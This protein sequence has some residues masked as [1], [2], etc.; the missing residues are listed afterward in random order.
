MSTSETYLSNPLLKKSNISIEFTTEQVEEYI[1]CGEDAEYFIEK[2]IKI[3]SIDKGLIS[4]VPYDYQRKMIQTFVDNRFV[5]AKCPRQSGKSTTVTSYLLWRILFFD[6]QNVAI[7]ANKGRLA[8]DLLEKIKLAYENLPKWIQQGVTTWNKGNIELENGSKVLAAATSSSAIRGGSYNTILLDEFA[9]IPRN[10]AEEFFTS[11]YPTISSGTTSQIIIVSTPHGM[12]HYYKMWVDA[13]EK[14]SLYIP[15]E[16]GWWETPGRDEAWKKQIIANTSEEQFRQEFE[17][18]FLGSANTLINPVKLKELTFK[19]P[20]TD[21]WGL[22]IYEEPKQNHL[23]IIP[24]DTAFGIGNDYSAFVVID[25]T[26]IPY[27]IVA[28][29]RSNKI[30]PMLYPEIICRYATWYN[31]AYILPE[32][33]DVGATV[34]QALHN[35]LEYENIIM[36]HN[37]VGLGQSISTGFGTQQT[38]FGI[39]MTKQVKRLGCSVLK[40]LVEENKI[41]IEDFDIINEFS[42]FISRS[43]SY[44]AED[45]YHDDLVM[46]LVIFC[47]FVRQ[48]FFKELSDTD[49][50]GRLAKEKYAAMLDDLLPPGFIDDGREENIT[51]MDGFIFY[52]D[53]PKL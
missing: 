37:K 27:R 48:P 1:R 24:V 40:D 23:Y 14:R 29:Y 18:V 44:E 45:G 17:C 19:T 11:V 8:N 16:V 5:L 21:K 20:Q 7:L 52:G 46:S 39:R 38:Q 51:N 47:W 33:N 26:E 34:A 50:R 9:Y 28:K 15:I 43:N 35:D 53:D 12:N 10:I 36:T 6:N 42:T 31:E 32:T 30:T 49:I 4:F 13:Q 22:N 41:I 2:Y 25:V 3:V